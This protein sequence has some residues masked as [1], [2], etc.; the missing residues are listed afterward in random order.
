[1][2]TNRWLSS[3]SRASRA[4]GF[5]A[6]AAALVVGTFFVITLRHLSDLE[7]QLNRWEAGV[8]EIASRSRSLGRD[9]F[10]NA[11]EEEEDAEVDWDF[12]VIHTLTTRF[13]QDQAHLIDLARAR[14]YLFEHFCLPTVLGQTIFTPF[15]AKE[16]FYSAEGNR[17][18]DVGPSGVP[19]FLWIIKVDPKLPPEILSRLISLISPYPQFYI[20]GSNFN[21]G[22][23]IKSGGWRG[24]Q[25][26]RDLLMAKKEGRLHCGDV[27][28]LRRAHAARNERIVLE[29]RL[30]A[31]DGLNF[32]YMEKVQI[33]A[34]KYLT[35]G[36]EDEVVEEGK[37]SNETAEWMYW[38]VF[39]HVAWE[40]SL[41]LPIANSNN[42]EMEGNESMETYGLFV[43][44][45]SPMACVTAG[46]TNGVSVGL[47]ERD[48]PRFAHQTI[49]QSFRGP[50]AT[51]ATCG[52][53]KRENCLKIISSPKVAAFRCRTPTSA[54]MKGV[55]GKLSKAEVIM[56]QKSR[57]PK[58]QK[59]MWAVLR[60]YFGITRELAK[61]ANDYVKEH[62]VE[63]A[64]DN[65]RGQCTR[66]HSC[67]L[68]AREELARMIDLAEAVR[69]NRKKEE[70]A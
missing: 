37:T 53:P 60:R 62:L 8:D 67:K 38:C 68:I 33:D 12:P 65:L 57:D 6:S 24:G 56:E 59:S 54:G 9:R 32:L 49:I 2:G 27:S 1:M 61:E 28:I 20:I 34:V 45:K 39:A 36:W 58:M 17:T 44:W 50:N 10:G 26:G 7:D 18:N 14:L 51:T 22:V 29:T 25:V 31:D 69:E 5:V 40:P 41:G 63:I 52:L 47:A 19:R 3:S 55:S 64:R 35:L 30:D 43:P 48:V 4:F 13:M 16:D 42:T 70:R 11:E 21:Y 23:G 66:G 15:A 46:L